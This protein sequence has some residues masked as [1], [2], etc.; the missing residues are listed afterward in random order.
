MTR[1]PCY[2]VGEYRPNKRPFHRQCANIANLDRAWE[3]YLTFIKGEG[4]TLYNIPEEK[5]REAAAKISVDHH[6]DAL[7]NPYAHIQLDLSMDDVKK[8]VNP[9]SYR[10]DS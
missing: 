9:S 10:P 3:H 6:K 5:T 8:M 4:W 7:D 1:L 2:A